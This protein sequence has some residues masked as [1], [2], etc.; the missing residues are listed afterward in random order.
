VPGVRAF[1]HRAHAVQ[2][3][4]AERRGKVAVGGAHARHESIVVEH[5]APRTAL[6]AG[7]LTG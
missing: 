5:L 2:R 3:G 1:A 4:N 7:L 6:L